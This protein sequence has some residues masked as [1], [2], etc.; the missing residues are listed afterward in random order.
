VTH[1]AESHVSFEF[2]TSVFFAHLYLYPED[3]VVA[4][5]FEHAVPLLILAADAGAAFNPPAITTAESSAI[6][7]LRDM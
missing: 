4:L 3:V 6:T 5:S 1:S 2:C 7:T